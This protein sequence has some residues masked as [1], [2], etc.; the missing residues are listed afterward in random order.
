MTGKSKGNVTKAVFA[1]AK[2]LAAALGLVI[3]DITFTK[4]G[5]QWYLRI[6]IDKPG[7]IFISDC[8][9]LSHAIDEPLEQ[10]D[11]IAS[12]YVLEVSSPGIE[13]ELRRKEHFEFAIGKVVAVK[14]IRPD[15]Q[16]QKSFKGKLLRYCE[17]NNS[18]QVEGYSNEIML[19]AVAIIKLFDE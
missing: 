2:P 8:E 10:L 1:L 18:I 19:S 11:P 4:E 6:Y 14:L 9:A 3:W 16:K 17:D 12:S 7:G 13:R 15:E 5:S